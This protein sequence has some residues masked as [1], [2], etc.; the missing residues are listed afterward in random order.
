MSPR[1]FIVIALTASAASCGPVTPGESADSVARR[2]LRAMLQG[3][4]QTIA[5]R[6]RSSCSSWK[7]DIEVS[8]GM[9]VEGKLTLAGDPDTLE[10]VQ[11][12]FAVDDE[13]TSVSRIQRDPG[14]RGTSDGVGA[15]LC[16]VE[17]ADLV[18]LGGGCIRLSKD[19]WLEVWCPDTASCEAL[20]TAKV[21]KDA[22]VLPSDSD[23]P[24]CFDE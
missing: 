15:S 6:T 7:V 23:R 19:E 13:R 5:I 12:Q 2:H 10:P 1:P 9:D 20:A 8:D 22:P 24:N 3:K 18:D 16:V 17:E 4:S 11:R 21:D 14:G